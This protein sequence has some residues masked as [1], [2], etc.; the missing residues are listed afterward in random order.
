M[1]SYLFKPLLFIYKY[2]RKNVFSVQSTSAILG[3]EILAP[4]LDTVIEDALLA[5]CKLSSIDLPCCLKAMKYPVKFA[6]HFR[7]FLQYFQYRQNS[8]YKN[9][10]AFFCSKI[11]TDSRPIWQ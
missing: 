5:F 1:T 6:A 11:E 7:A 3:I 8:P 2:Y 10:P 9:P 4:F